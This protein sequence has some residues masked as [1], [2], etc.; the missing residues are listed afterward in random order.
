MKRP[1]KGKTVL[2]MAA[3]VLLAWVMWYGRPVNIYSLGAK[4]A[5]LQIIAYVDLYT[6]GDGEYRGAE[7]TGTRRVDLAADT[8]EGQAVLDKLED[9]YFR[10]SLLNPLRQLLPARGTGAQLDD[11]EMTFVI[12]VFTADGYVLLQF[13]DG[14]WSYNTPE[15]MNYFPCDLPDGEAAGRTLGETLWNLP[16]AKEVPS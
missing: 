12:D 8:P 6:G 5:P 9:L 1:S 16:Q 7:R 14:K 13:F 10:R 15:Q 3:A 4:G 2:L 11:G